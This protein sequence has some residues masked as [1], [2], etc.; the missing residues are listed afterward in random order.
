[1]DGLWVLAFGVMG[2]GQFLPGQ[3]GNPAGRPKGSSGGRV[4]ALMKLDEMLSKKRNE[5]V[6]M[7]AME[8]ELL[9]DPVGFFKSVVMPLLPKESRLSFENEGV[10]Q[11]QTLLGTTVTK[12]D[13]ENA[14]RGAL[15]AARRALP[16]SS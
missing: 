3:S 1:M 7:Q 16:D 5:R 14:P 15:N 9:R 12:E 6:L 8:A 4:R 10:V 13:L 11:W 2:M